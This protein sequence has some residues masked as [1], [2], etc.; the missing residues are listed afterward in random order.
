MKVSEG[1]GKETEQENIEVLE[2]KFPDALLAVKKGDIRDAKTI[3]LLQFA[4]INR[5]LEE[6]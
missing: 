5:L 1:G 3:L 6:K 4:L 2:M